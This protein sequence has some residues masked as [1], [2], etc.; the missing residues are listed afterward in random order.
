MLNFILSLHCFSN[1]GFLNFKTKLKCGL[2]QGTL[3]KILYENELC[4]RSS[5]LNI[6]FLEK[7]NASAPNDPQMTLNVTR[8]KVLL[9]HVDVPLVLFPSLKCHFVSL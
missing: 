5:V 6:I 4:G 9:D 8:P 2:S 3:I 1:F 7:K